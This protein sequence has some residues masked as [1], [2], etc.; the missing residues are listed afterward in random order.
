[1]ELIIYSICFYVMF[2]DYNFKVLPHNLSGPSGQL[3]KM[4]K[5]TSSPDKML[6]QR[7]I[8]GYC[9]YHE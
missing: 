3:K 9:L 6:H 2:A 1:M 7:M 8:I 4:D 5:D